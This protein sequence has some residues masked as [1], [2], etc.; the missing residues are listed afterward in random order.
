MLLDPSPIAAPPV[1]DRFGENSQRWRRL[2]AADGTDDRMLDEVLEEMWKQV[3]LETSTSGS[4][5]VRS[6]TR[7]AGFSRRSWSACSNE[8]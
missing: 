3:K 5:L 1:A 7:G 2:S 8:V 6:V 4:S